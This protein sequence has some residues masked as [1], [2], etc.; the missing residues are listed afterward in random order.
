MNNP[1][2]N[3]GKIEVRKINSERVEYFKIVNKKRV[4]QLSMYTKI[5]Y[6]IIFSTKE[7]KRVLLEDNR[8]QLYKYIWGILKKKNCHLYRINGVEDHI[9]IFTHL[10]PSIA[11]ADLIKDIKLASSD[12]I[13]NEKIFPGFF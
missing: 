7:R 13:K 10:H 9:H 6:Q 5:L 2:C 1:E 3:S 11:L 4:L 12:M 8:E